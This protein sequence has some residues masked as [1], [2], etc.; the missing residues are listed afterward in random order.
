MIREDP[1][2]NTK[3]L[4]KAVINILKR[5]SLRVMPYD[6]FILTPCG[7]HLPINLLYLAPNAYILR[8][9][10]LTKAK[11][12]RVKRVLVKVHVDIVLCSGRYVWI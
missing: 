3:I 11:L 8:G 10:N 9:G 4:N 6:I 5:L 2:A 1:L 7:N 12:F